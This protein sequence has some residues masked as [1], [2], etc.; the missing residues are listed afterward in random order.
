MIESFETRIDLEQKI[1]AVRSGQPT[2][3]FG[4]VQRVQEKPFG[5][6]GSIL[7][8]PKL[9]WEWISNACKRDSPGRLP[10]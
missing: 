6:V 10:V 3:G 9:T 8:L 4:S 2:R 7:H 1:A 5:M